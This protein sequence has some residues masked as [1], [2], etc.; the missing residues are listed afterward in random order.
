MMS[1]PN[2]FLD[3]SI[4]YFRKSND[5]KYQEF[6]NLISSNRILIIND[7]V[8]LEVL[9]GINYKDE[10]LYKKFV[11]LFDSRFE[12]KE[13][14]REIYK[15]AREVDRKLKAEGVTLKKGKTKD[16]AGVIDIVNFCTAKYY[17]CEIFHNDNDFEKIEGVW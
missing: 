10:N 1:N 6:K 9:Q 11:K 15:M 4:I 7:L 17:E 12:V 8:R 16:I 14:N 13:I 5:A 2:A 3:S